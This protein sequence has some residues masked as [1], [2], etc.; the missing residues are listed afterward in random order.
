MIIR[1]GKTLSAFAFA[2]LQAVFSLCGA[3]CSYAQEQ[4]PFAELPSGVPVSGIKA[5]GIDPSDKEK[6]LNKLR[7]D[8]AYRGKIADKM[9]ESGVAGT[10]VNLSG[11]PTYSE[12]REAVIHWIT[13]NPEKAAAY[14]VMLSGKPGSDGTSSAQGVNGPGYGVGYGGK[15]YV[16][17][18]DGSIIKTIYTYSLSNTFLK[19]IKALTAAASDRSLSAENLADA[20]RRLFEGTSPYQGTL[21]TDFDAVAGIQTSAGGK[22]RKR[23]HSGGYRAARYSGQYDNIK[24]NRAAL[25]SETSRAEQLLSAMR[26]AGN[27]PEGAEQYYAYAWK[28]YSN[29][30]G[31]SSPLKSR[32]VITGKEA[33]SLEQLRTDLRKALAGLSLKL[34]SL[35]TEE[36]SRSLDDTAAGYD[37]LRKAM[38]RLIEEIDEKLAEAGGLN[39]SAEITRILSEAQAAFSAL[40]MA[41]SVYN[42]VFELGKQ[43]SGL[44]F[45]CLYDKFVFSLLN[46]IAPESP[47]VRVRNEAKGAVSQLSAVLKKAA[48]GDIMEALEKGRVD[49]L[50]ALI[51]EAEEYSRR[52]R[53]AQY[54]AWGILFRPFEIEITVKKINQK[55]HAFFRVA[56][57][58]M[59]YHA[60]KML[61]LAPAPSDYEKNGSP[62]QKE[63][64]SSSAV[65]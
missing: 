1:C 48:S 54:Y 58:W 20:G 10:V 19:R 33:D 30:A 18:E 25:D 52:N 39:D 27:G 59:D 2:L 32:K 63:G 43:A 22:G 28:A 64:S 47:Y 44:G 41:Y 45:S 34:M 3:P 31:Y 65:S 7:T 23:S 15:D 9:L 60:E 38:R 55:K 50:R 37:E 49:N 12:A 26:G 21:E 6:V 51:D 56:F 42:T 29:F 17:N 57:P 8:L 46:I 13:R 36:L 40:Y 24:I 11:S 16:V 61:R 62:G 53:E 4:E 35:Y 14:A 5:A